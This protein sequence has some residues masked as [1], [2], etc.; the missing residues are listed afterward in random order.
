MKDFFLLYICAAFTSFTLAHYI[1]EYLWTIEK[2]P[3][4]AIVFQETKEVLFAIIEFSCFSY[5]M[6]KA[7]KQHSRKLIKLFSV[8]FSLSVL[9]FIQKIVIGSSASEIRHFSFIVSSTE[10]GLL[11]I[12]CLIYLYEL[13]KEKTEENLFQKPSFWIVSGLFIYSVI[14]IPFSLVADKFVKT[15]DRIIKIGFTMH[16]I[17]F[18]LLFLALIKAFSLKK[19]LSD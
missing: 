4:V 5:F 1:W 12:P 7:L 2:K 14:I 19:T 6:F 3:E 10:M 13:L 8:F 18:S 9:L 17:S 11:L 15:N 16:L